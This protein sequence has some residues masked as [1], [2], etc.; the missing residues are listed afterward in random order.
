MLI[1]NGSSYIK[2]IRIGFRS[3]ESLVETRTVDKILFL[4][5]MNKNE[6]MDEINILL[7]CLYC[8]WNY[9]IKPNL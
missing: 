4:G 9:V 3:N 1:L 6:E 8:E 7:K 5:N 2:D